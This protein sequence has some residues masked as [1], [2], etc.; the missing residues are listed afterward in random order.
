ME[1]AW[2]ISNLREQVYF[3]LHDS[4]E[5]GGKHYRSIRYKADFVYEKNWQ[6]IVEDTKSTPTRKLQSF[7][8]KMKML[9]KR[10]PNI[11]FIIT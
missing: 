1:K 5:H 2:I 11:T 6:T 7:Q 10:Y 8:D 4:F 9:I 3:I